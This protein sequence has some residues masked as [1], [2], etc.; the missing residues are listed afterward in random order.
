MY[1]NMYLNLC[2]KHMWF[3]SY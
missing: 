1:K 2:T 3:L